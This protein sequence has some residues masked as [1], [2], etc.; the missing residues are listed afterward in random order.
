MA[1]NRGNFHGALF[2]RPVP[3][4]LIKEGERGV[5]R[6][7]ATRIALEVKVR[8]LPLSEFLTLIFDALE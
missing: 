3:A 7:H 6:E 2:E 5:Y 4:D 8:L 1:S